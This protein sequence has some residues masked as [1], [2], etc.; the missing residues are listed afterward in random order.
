DARAALRL[1]EDLVADRA[2][3]E[4]RLELL[5]AWYRDLATLASGGAPEDLI[6]CDLG[7]FAAASAARLGAPEA[8]RRI[9]LCRSARAKLR[10]NASPRLQTEQLLLRF[11]FPDA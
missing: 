1:A 3:A 8:L 9:E 11:L 4:T 5:E 2:S 6:N 10:F 7:E